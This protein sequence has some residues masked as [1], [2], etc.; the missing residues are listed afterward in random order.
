MSGAN[1]RRAVPWVLGVSLLAATLVVVGSGGRLLRSNDAS[2]GA[3]DGGPKRNPAPPPVTGGTTFIG[4]VDSEPSPAHV[5][6]PAV[7]A[8]ATVKEVKVTEGRD[9]KPGDP[10][11][12]FDDA[13]FKAKLEEAQAE[14]GAARLDVKKAEVAKKNHGIQVSRQEAAVKVAEDMQ[15]LAQDTYDIAL[16]QNDEALRILKITEKD[17]TTR[18]LTAEEKAQRTRENFDLRKLEA[19]VLE[20]KAKAA[21]AKKLLTSLELDPVDIQLEQAAAKVCRLQATVKEA[22]AAVDACL[23]KADSAGVVE[24]L[25]ATPGMTFGPATRV[26]VLVLVPSG[27]RIV[28]AEVEAEFAAKV[29]GTEGKKVTIT[30]HHKFDLTYEGVVRRVGTAFLPKR[31]AD[32]ALNLNPTKVLEVLVDVPDP[33]PPGR[34]PL[35]VGQPV[36]VTFQ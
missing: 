26:P 19:T 6:P 24:E 10:L 36:R 34:P 30:D 28:R 21:D 15:K 1:R 31:S 11:V 18:P 20:A 29:A 22:Q 16:R 27:K 3:G 9:V 2:P 17:G 7:S 32:S 12:Q 33:T 23:V 25:A 5:G 13:I 35:R 8:L 14:L 4:T